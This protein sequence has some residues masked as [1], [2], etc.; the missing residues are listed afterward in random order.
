MEILHSFGL[1]IKQF[2]AQVVNFL[3]IVLIIKTFLYQ[4]LR[5][6]LRERQEKIKKGL[7]DSQA[8]TLMLEKTAQDK[9]EILKAA[10][11][12]MQNIIETARGTAEQIKQNIVDESQKAAEK[13]VAQAKIE[14]Q[15]EMERMEQQVK[16]MSLVLTQKVLA[17]LLPTLF[18]E[19]QKVAI[20]KKAVASLEQGPHEHGNH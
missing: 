1:D 8:A 20:L 15:L 17:T 18:S 4:P 2:A 19:E 9:A 5:A 6:V 12:E 13:I 7:D 11:F 10:R 16:S 3:V 14:A